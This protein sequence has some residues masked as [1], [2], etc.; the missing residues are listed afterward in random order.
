MFVIFL[1]VCLIIICFAFIGLFYGIVLATAL[2]Q[3]VVQRHLHLLD[4]REIAREYPVAD[5]ATPLD[6]DIPY[7]EVVR[8]VRE[9][10]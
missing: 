3:R 7:A 4:L 6:Q 5:F 9:L 1:V 10:L 8:E 2:F